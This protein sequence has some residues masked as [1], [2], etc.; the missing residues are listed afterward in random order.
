MTT[1][2]VGYAVALHAQ[3][4]TSRQS[5]RTTPG[6]VTITGC[7]ERAD[8]VAAS[9]TP[10]VTVDSL[11]FVL[12]HAVTGTAADAPTGT[13]GSS[14]SS[15]VAKRGLYKLDGALSALNPHVGHKVEVTGTLVPA[16]APPADATDPT[17]AENAPKMHVDHL[18]MVSE[19][20]DR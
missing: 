12:I 18:R 4:P 15:A 16:S 6:A 3:A 5:N 1:F 14:A 13:S 10:G 17:S 20:C 9:T 7:V 19:T 11:S 8:Q 2:A